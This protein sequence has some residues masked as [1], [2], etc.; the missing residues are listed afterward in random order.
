[1][2]FD[3]DFRKVGGRTLAESARE[4]DISGARDQLLM[5]HFRQCILANMSG[6]GE[7]IWDYGDNEPGDQVAQ[8]ME[9]DESGRRLYLEL[10]HRLAVTG[11]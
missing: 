3:L 9:E 10:A 6:T 4:N 2:N 8:I 11:S 5:W 1:M 7:P